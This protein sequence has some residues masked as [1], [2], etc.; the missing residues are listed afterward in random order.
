LAQV[1]EKKDEQSSQATQYWQQCRQLI[2]S[3]LA[4]GET[5]NPEE[6]RWLYEA[7]QKL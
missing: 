7:K 5:I 6:D 2:E 1:L 4:A 3:R